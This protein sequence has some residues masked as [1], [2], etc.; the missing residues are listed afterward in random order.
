MRQTIAL[1]KI[2]VCRWKYAKPQ[3]FF[4]NSERKECTNAPRHQVVCHKIQIGKKRKDLPYGK[5]VVKLPATPPLYDQP[6]LVFRFQGIKDVAQ[7]AFL[8]RL[9]KKAFLSR[10]HKKSSCQVYKKE[11]SKMGMVT[12]FVEDCHEDIENNK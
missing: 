3:K 6:N 4:S 7:K 2:S 8:S 9:Q 12:H 1:P 11:K 5:G 10:L